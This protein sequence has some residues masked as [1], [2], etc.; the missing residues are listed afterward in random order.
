VQKLFRFVFAAIFLAGATTPCLAAETVSY[1]ETTAV[2]TVDVPNGWEAKHEHGAVR[3]LA[4][5]ADA[6]FLLQHV[7]NV[8]DENTAKEALPELANLQGKQFSLDEIKV[9]IPTAAAE[10]GDFKGVLMQCTGKDKHG[11]DTFWQVM[12]FAPKSNDYYLMTCLWTEQDA[13]KTDTDRGN[14]FRSLKAVQG[15]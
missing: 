3:I 6:V 15:K 11:N 10:M 1:P 5:Q 4:Q 13:E 14:I 2:F 7:D 9:T 12:I 8:K